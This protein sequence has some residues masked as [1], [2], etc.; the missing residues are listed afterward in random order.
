VVLLIYTIVR[1][2]GASRRV[3]TLAGLGILLDNALL[4]ESRLIL[5]DGLLIFFGLCG[6]SLYLLPTGI[7]GGGRWLRRRLLA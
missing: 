1:Q 2:L 6:L 5:L 4:V 7:V 3:A